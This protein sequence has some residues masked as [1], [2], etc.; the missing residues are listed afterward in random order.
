MVVGS[1]EVV[2]VNIEGREAGGRGLAEAVRGGKIV[3]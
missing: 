3:E 2:G 1:A